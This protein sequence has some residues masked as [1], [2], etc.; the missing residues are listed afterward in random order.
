MATQ[1]TVLPPLQ[2]ALPRPHWSFR[3][4]ATELTVASLLGVILMSTLYLGLAGGSAALSHRLKETASE[5]TR[6]Q[7][8]RAE[9]LRKLAQSQWAD[10][11]YLDDRAYAQGFREPSAVLHLDWSPSATQQVTER[12]APT[13]GPGTPATTMDWWEAL[14]NHFLAWIPEPP[15]FLRP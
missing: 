10:P 11:A 15:A 6:L 7:W 4:W 8:E 9:K 1:Q 5:N 2:R 12:T 13:T 3:S 14:V